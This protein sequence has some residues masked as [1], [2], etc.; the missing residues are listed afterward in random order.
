MTGFLK[1]EYDC[2]KVIR[3]IQIMK[4][5]RNAAK[6]MQSCFF[7]ELLDLIIPESQL[8]CKQIKDIFLVM[9]LERTDLNTLM[10]NGSEI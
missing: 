3:E 6:H 9:E 4:G 2:V 7:P 8:Y 1:Y 5:L 10:H